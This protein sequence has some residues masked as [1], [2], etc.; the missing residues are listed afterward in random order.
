MRVER[1]KTSE[2]SSGCAASR[3]APCS[4][5]RSRVFTS[6]V[7]M[8][9]VSRCSLCTGPSSAYACAQTKAE[10]LLSTLLDNDRPD[11]LEEPPLAVRAWHDYLSLATT[12]PALLV[13]RVFG[14]PWLRW[15]RAFMVQ[16]A[17]TSFEILRGKTLRE[18]WE[19]RG[20]GEERPCTARPTLFCTACQMPQQS[21]CI[22]WPSKIDMGTPCIHYPRSIRVL[23]QV[24]K[25]PLQQAVHDDLLPA[26][27]FAACPSSERAGHRTL[28]MVYIRLP[29]ASS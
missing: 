12:S 2:S 16:N 26:G 8:P 19:K 21:R 18:K 23:L 5:K 14:D 24:S 10:T 11:I 4:A 7:R 13:H 6:G 20:K 22:A 25:G 29:A 27:V 3:P 1:R 9:S 28:L 15:Y 17:P